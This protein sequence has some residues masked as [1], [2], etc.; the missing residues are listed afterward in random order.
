M[1]SFTEP[2]YTL[3]SLAFSSVAACTLQM[4]TMGNII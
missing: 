1:A 4:V 3:F 2:F